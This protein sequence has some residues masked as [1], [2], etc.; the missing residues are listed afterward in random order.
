M[1]ILDC[2][3]A[4]SSQLCNVADICNL[5]QVG[6]ES[7]QRACVMLFRVGK[8]EAWLFYCTAFFALKSADLKDQFHLFITDWQHFKGAFNLPKSNDIARFAVWT[9]EIIV[10]Y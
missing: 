9:F 8:T 10:V 6:D 4:K 2:V 5:A 7:F 3:P 1:N